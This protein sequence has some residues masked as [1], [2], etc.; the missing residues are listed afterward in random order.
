MEKAKG[1]GDAPTL[2]QFLACARQADIARLIGRDGKG[3]RDVSRRVF[4]IFVSQGDA[5]DVRARTYLHAYWITFEGNATARVALGRAYRAG[6]E[7]SDALANINTS[8]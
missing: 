7:F 2:E 4:G 3:T 8:A 1:T 5:L 6:E